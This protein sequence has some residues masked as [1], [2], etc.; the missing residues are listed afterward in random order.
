MALVYY[1]DVRDAMVYSL[2]ADTWS[3]LREHGIP[4]LALSIGVPPLV[5][6]SIITYSIGCF[7]VHLIESIGFVVLIFKPNNGGMML[8]C[9]VMKLKL[10]LKLKLSQQILASTV[11]IGVTNNAS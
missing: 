6:L 10:K 3:W 1:D 4:R 7:G 8:H 2:K 5:P 11:V 9:L